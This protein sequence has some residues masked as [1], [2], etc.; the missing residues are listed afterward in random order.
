[1]EKYIYELEDS[2]EG[3]DI[4]K[5]IQTKR[6]I[7]VNYIINSETNKRCLLEGFKLF[8]ISINICKTNKWLDYVEP[9][10]IIPL[11][12]AEKAKSLKPFTPETLEDIIKDL[13]RDYPIELGLYSKNN[14]S[15]I[16]DEKYN[17]NCVSS[18]IFS[19]YIKTSNIGIV[20]NAFK[21][22]N[23]IKN[24]EWFYDREI[25]IFYNKDISNWGIDRWK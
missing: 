12:T 15:F 3:I 2:F 13:K 7:S 18:N 25:D 23:C 22:R 14:Y 19:N 20:Y 11:K 6:C 10:L 9:N 1:M 16:C 17:Y 21:G 5:K 24:G 8:Q 4:S